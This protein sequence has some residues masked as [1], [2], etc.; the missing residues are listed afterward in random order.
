MKI[1]N[2]IYVILIA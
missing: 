2:G 1:R